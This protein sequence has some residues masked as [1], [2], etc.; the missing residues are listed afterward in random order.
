M[1]PSARRHSTYGS[2]GT[3]LT[4]VSLCSRALSTWMGPDMPPLP[5]P[6]ALPVLA[7]V[8]PRLA[9]QVGGAAAG[10]AARIP[11]PAAVHGFG[12]APAVSYRQQCSLRR[13]QR[14]SGREGQTAEASH[15]PPPSSGCWR[16]PLRAWRA[17]SDAF[18]IHELWLGGDKR[19]RGTHK[20]KRAGHGAR[21][22]AA[23]RLAGPTCAPDQADAVAAPQAPLQSPLALALTGPSVALA[24]RPPSRS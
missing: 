10:G 1:V 16:L 15:P 22:A 20:L 21:G 19:R 7:L 24:L 3:E 5:L 18:I 11:R 13:V 2:S 14:G 8:L 23:A 4:G 17:A 6:A 12:P 9:V